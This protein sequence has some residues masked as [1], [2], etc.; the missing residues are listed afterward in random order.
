MYAGV[1]IIYYLNL[2]KIILPRPDFSSAVSPKKYNIN[3]LH[4]V[5]T[6]QTD[7]SRNSPLFISKCND[8]GKINVMP[9]K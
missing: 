6:A 1:F 5:E 2:E 8:A 4:I 9:V 3:A 7:I